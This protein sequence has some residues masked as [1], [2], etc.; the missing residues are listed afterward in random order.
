[1]GKKKAMFIYGMGTFDGDQAYHYTCDSKCWSNWAGTDYNVLKNNCNTFTSTVLSCVY[2]LSQKKPHLGISDMVTV[3]GHC[4]ASEAQPRDPAFMFKEFEEKFERQYASAE[5]RAARYAVFAENVE[6][7]AAMRVMDTSAEYSHLSPFADMTDEEFRARNGFRGAPHDLSAMEE[8]VLPKL[9]TTDLP[10]DF[11]WTTQGA[12]TPV[13]NQ[14]QCAAESSKEK[15]F[16]SGYKVVDGT[17]E[18]QLAAALMQYGPLAIGINATPMQ[19]Y[20]GGVANPLSF[21]CNPKSL[22]HGVTIVGFG[23]DGGK[24]YWKIKNSWGQSWGEKG[25]YRIIRGVGKCGLNTNVATATMADEL[26]V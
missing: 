4:P 11:D 16:I 17:D 2:G 9:D 22:D 25:Y 10:T 14:G 21:L 20:M 7:I 6:K 26:V 8:L 12:V 24:K 15:V 5:E 19:W 23:V 1:M 18:D 13:K 3:S